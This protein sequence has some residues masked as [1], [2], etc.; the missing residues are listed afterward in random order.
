[1]IILFLVRLDLEI[2]VALAALF[3]K[4]GREVV[5]PFYQFVQ[6]FLCVFII[7]KK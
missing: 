1:M 2:Y 5:I 7:D 3:L 6:A 4:E